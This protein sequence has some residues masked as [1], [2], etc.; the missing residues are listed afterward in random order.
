MT[1][2]AGNGRDLSLRSE[3]VAPPPDERAALDA[4][5]RGDLHGTIEVLMA[6]YGRAVH[7]YSCRLVGDQ[8]AAEDVLQT[9]FLQAFVD[10]PRFARRSSL[11]VWLFGIAHHRC[12]DAL[13]A[14]RRLRWRFPGMDENAPE[15][16]APAS[17]DDHAYG[18]RLGESLARCLESLKEAVRTAVLLRYAEEFSYGEMAEVCG[19]KAP[20]LQARVAR[21]LPLLRR[22]L[23]RQGVHV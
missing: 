22:C 6:L 3:T 13:K 2:L 19:E 12:L 18:S 9:T 5:D 4:L 1:A 16:A 17:R 23:E 15:P 8:H 7:R 14:R 21:A 11:R 20:T 10:L